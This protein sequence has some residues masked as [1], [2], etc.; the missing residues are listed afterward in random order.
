[1]AA[2]AMSAQMI[3]QRQM[4]AYN[5]RD[6]DE[7]CSYFAPDAV[8]RLYENDQLLAVGSEELRALY[9]RRFAENPNLQLTVQ[10]RMVLDNVVIDRELISGFD[11]GVTIEALAIF[12]IHNGLIQR[13][14]FIRR[15]V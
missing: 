15:Q 6:V 3:V 14:S 13:A 8:T 7:F 10:S 12:E 4:E 1:M 11:G 5:R 9:A 2:D